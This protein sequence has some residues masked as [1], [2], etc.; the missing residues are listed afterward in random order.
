MREFADPGSWTTAAIEL[1]RKAE[2]T[3]TLQ[4]LS[5]AGVSPLL[6]KGAAL[7]YMLYPEPAQRPRSDTDI[8]ISSDQ[9]AWAFAALEQL[10]YLRIEAVGGD[11]ITSEATFQRER[12]GLRH[13]VDVHW[14]ANNSPLLWSVIDYAAVARRAIRI[15]ELGE[16]AWG[17]SHG[18]A[19]LMACVH[20]ASHFHAPMY[21]ADG[22]TRYGD[23]SVWLY[24]IHLL[25]GCLGTGDWTDFVR[26][27]A[28]SKVRTLAL[29][30]LRA[31]QQ[32]FGTSIPEAV[33]AELDDY[34]RQEPSSAFLHGTPLSLKWHEFWALPTWPLRVSFFRQHLF[35][36]AAYLLQK[37]SAG[38]KSWLPWL[39]LRRFLGGLGKL[40]RKPATDAD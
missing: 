1:A 30:A 35:P 20:R 40:L 25:A 21:E 4:A 12:L 15:P 33:R 39:Y 28:R 2:L 38:S 8:L 26:E 9:Q 24:D 36:P 10:G 3:E 31:A 7:A 23:W 22:Q 5:S 14:R 11:T 13:V 19:L 17:L 27:A 37:Y 32:M 16:R 29:D 18:D 6:L 34:R